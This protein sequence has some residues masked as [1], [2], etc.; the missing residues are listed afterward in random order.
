[1]LRALWLVYASDRAK[2]IEKLLTL[3]TDFF[4][5]LFFLLIVLSA[6]LSTLAFSVFCF[7]IAPRKSESPFIYYR[8]NRAIYELTLIYLLIFIYFTQ[9]YSPYTF[10]LSK[11]KASIRNYSYRMIYNF[12]YFRYRYF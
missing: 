7:A 11:K 12:R 8:F 1:M 3:Y 9:N 4:F 5:L 2:N 6:I 10:Y